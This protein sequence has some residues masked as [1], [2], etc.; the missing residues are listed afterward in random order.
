MHA[1]ANSAAGS[2]T[3]GPVR[4]GALR[5][6]EVE[7]WVS[8]LGL[9]S[10]AGHQILAADLLGGSRVGIRVGPATL[11]FYDLA[12][13]ELLRTRNNPLTP[14][15]QRT[16]WRPPGRTPATALGDPPSADGNPSQISRPITSRRALA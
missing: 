14:A 4:V 5:S 3:G 9:V 10:L 8:R 6:V 1:A 16:A 13:R 7:R 11:M 12:T 2:R 15:S